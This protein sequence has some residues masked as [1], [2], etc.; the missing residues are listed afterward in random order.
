MAR[1]GT[2]ALLRSRGGHGHARVTNI[3]L[4]CDLVFVFG[5]THLLALLAAFGGHW[6]PLSVS[7]GAAIAM[8]VVAGWETRALRLNRPGPPGR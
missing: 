5:V 6:E 7:I 1:R 4:F 3:E 2:G 8:V